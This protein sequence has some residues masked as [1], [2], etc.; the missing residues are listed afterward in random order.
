[1]L[2]EQVKYQINQD[3]LGSAI[4]RFN[5]INLDALNA[6]SL[7]NRVDTKYLIHKRQLKNILTSIQPYYKAL[8]VD[9]VS[10]VVYD[11]MYFDTDD[12]VMYLSHHNGRLNRQKI[13]RRTYHTGTSFLEIKTK[14]N[15]GRTQKIRVR[16]LDPNSQFSN[17]ENAY[18]S[19]HTGF[20]PQHLVHKLS[21]QFTRI[22]LINNEMTERCTIDTNISY[23]D[24]NADRNLDDT[25]II[26]LK[27]DKSNK[28]SKMKLILDSMGIKRVNFSKYCM[29]RVMLDPALKANKFKSRMLSMKKLQTNDSLI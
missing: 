12:D 9:G 5:K 26:E 22:T 29:G 2:M 24:Q 6:V 15:K 13:R 10:K 27:N 17:L 23:E 21:N 14:T 25:V 20:D 8:E 3:I 7:M 11:N 19:E 1:M 28:D 4:A 18:I 16:S